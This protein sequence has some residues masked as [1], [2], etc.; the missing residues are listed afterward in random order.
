[1]AGKTGIV[2]PSAGV[3]EGPNICM[4]DHVSAV[5]HRDLK[6]SSL[7]VV[8]F[9]DAVNAVKVHKVSIW[10]LGIC[11]TAEAWH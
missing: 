3:A 8:R 4:C 10:S 7:P 9:H 2:V 11:L 1:M 5:V 6:S